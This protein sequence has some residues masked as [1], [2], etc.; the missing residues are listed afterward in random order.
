MKG[1][2]EG[3]AIKLKS[4]ENSRSSLNLVANFK[5]ILNEDF[6]PKDN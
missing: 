3:D 2:I 1:N 4:V 6:G 5:C